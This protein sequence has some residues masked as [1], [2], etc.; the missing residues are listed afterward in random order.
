[1]SITRRVVLRQLAA[2]AAARSSPAGAAVASGRASVE[3]GSR[4]PV[5]LDRNENGYGPSPR[6]LAALREA[7]ESSAHRHPDAAADALFDV[8]GAAHGVARDRILVGCGSTEILHMAVAA[9]VGPGRKLVLA[10][11]TFDVVA[12]YAERSGSEVIAI[13][14]TRYHAHDL[15][16]MLAR[17]DAATGL[18]YI[19]NPN[20]PTGTLTRR[21]DLDAFIHALPPTTRVLI[22]EAY[23]HY[24]GPASSYASFIDRP[25]DDPRVIVTRSFSKIHG[26]AGLRVGYGVMDRE[27]AHLLETHR[28][29]E[30]VNTLAAA[31]AAIAATDTTHLQLSFQRNVND[32]QELL[33]QA[34]ARM[35][36]GIDPV[37][38]FVMLNTER[39]AA[40]IVEHFRAHGVRIAGPFSPFDTYIRVSVGTPEEMREFWRV[41][42]LMPVHKMSM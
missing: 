36:K 29:D 42:D 33:N 41:W 34:N 30:S 25:I 24:V 17:A 8:L 11:P 10:R 1:M 12:R 18:V 19:C 21:D 9:F 27:T 20:S 26:L 37:A 6:V 32:R 2:A 31:A 16:A 14:L 40:G 4:E 23:H 22:D 28:L 15:D 3:A 39:P 5:R 13:P 35:L 38:N 7:A